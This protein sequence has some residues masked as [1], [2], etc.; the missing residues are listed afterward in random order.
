MELKGKALYN[1]LRSSWQEDPSISFKPWQI[2]DYRKL[3]EA[4][5]FSR[6]RRL[7]IVLDHPS[8]MVYAEDCE[9]PE[10]LVDCLCCDDENLEK[11]DETFLIVCELWRRHLPDRPSLSLFCDE[12]DLLFAAYDNQMLDD[13]EKL[14]IALSDLRDILDEAVD[15]GSSALDAFENVANHCA[16]DLE[17]FLYDYISDQIEAHNDLNASELLDAFY[18]YVSDQKRF[19]FLRARIFAES[20]IAEGNLLIARLLEVLAE[21]PDLSLLLEMAEYLVNRGDVHLFMQAVRQAIPLLEQEDDLQNLMQQIAAYYRCLDRE[22][23]EKEIE[24]LL[25][26]RSTYPFDRPIAPTDP[27][28]KHIVEIFAL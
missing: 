3:T 14:Q 9:S 20:D 25:S 4:D 16:H 10:E 8:F 1:L 22:H 12:L 15:Q 11:N 13:E 5:L 6:L 24:R 23:E 27:A 17:S 2:E 19:D 7:S 18:E 28:L 26:A 21:M